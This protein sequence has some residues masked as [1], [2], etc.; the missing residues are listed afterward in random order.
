MFA[1]EDALAVQLARKVRTSVKPWV[2]RESSWR[3]KLGC[4]RKDGPLFVL[5]DKHLTGGRHGSVS[6]SNFFLNPGTQVV[7]MVEV[8]SFGPTLLA[9][10]GPAA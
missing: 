9:R 8:A 4:D 2:I 1:C 7:P 5:R 6:C 10:Q 3:K